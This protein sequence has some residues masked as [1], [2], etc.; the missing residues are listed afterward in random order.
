MSRPPGR[1]IEMPDRVRVPVDMDA[2][3]R[4]HLDKQ[5]RARD[6]SRNQLIRWAIE[7]GLPHL[8]A[9]LKPESAA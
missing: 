5:A 6:V 7:A 3:L 4:D 8:P 9:L 2:S 1:P